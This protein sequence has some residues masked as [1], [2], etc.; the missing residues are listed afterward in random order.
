MLPS[1]I[2][3]RLEGSSFNDTRFLA[4]SVAVPK[5]TVPVGLFLGCHKCFVLISIDGLGSISVL[6]GFGGIR[7]GGIMVLEEDSILRREIECWT[8]WSVGSSSFFGSS[9]GFSWGS[10]FF[11]VLWR[12]GVFVGFDDGGG[13]GVAGGGARGGG[14]A[15]GLGAAK[16]PEK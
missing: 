2:L 16:Y 11:E 14:G 3:R 9:F 6:A 12:F 1:R 10:D 4:V 5:E 8:A 7:G 13:G 15:P